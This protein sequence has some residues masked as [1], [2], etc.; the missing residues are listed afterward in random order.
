[1]KLPKLNI[2]LSKLNSNI[3]LNHEKYKQKQW[4]PHKKPRIKSYHKSNTDTTS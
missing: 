2:K 4:K 3:K 1:M